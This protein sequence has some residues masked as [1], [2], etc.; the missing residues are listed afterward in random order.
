LIWLRLCMPPFGLVLQLGHSLLSLE[1][2]TMLR[3]WR[4]TSVTPG[5]LPEPQPKINKPVL[6][7]FH[8]SS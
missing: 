8:I 1:E 4:N 7:V 5:S 6:S 2:T 3:Q